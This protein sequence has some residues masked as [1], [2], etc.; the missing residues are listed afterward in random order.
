M[1]HWIGG[2]LFSEATGRQRIV[3]VRS[4]LEGSPIPPDGLR[5]LGFGVLALLPFWPT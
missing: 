4:F 1:H 5:W 3:E 2:N